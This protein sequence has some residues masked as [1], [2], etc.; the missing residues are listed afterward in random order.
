VVFVVATTVVLTWVQVRNCRLGMLAA[1]GFAVQAWVT[2]KGPIEN[3]VDH[4]NDPFGQNSKSSTL[5]QTSNCIWP[6]TIGC[7]APILCQNA[8]EI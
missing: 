7:P 2:G 6:Y 8:N 5:S 3:A 1:L 4:L